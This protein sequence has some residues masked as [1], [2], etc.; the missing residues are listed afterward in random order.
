VGLTDAWTRILAL[1]RT[2]LALETI[3]QEQRAQ[4]ILLQRIADQIAP[5]RP[6]ASEADLKQT[7]A[8]HISYDD[9]GKIQDFTEDIQRKLG[10]EPTEQEI[11]DFLDGVDVRLE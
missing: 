10:R 8:S 7:G 4:T 1:R 11:V 3:A 2:I 6:L 5:E 9:M